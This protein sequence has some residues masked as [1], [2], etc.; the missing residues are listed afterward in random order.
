MMYCERCAHHQHDRRQCTFQTY[1]LLSNINSTMGITRLYSKCK[2]VGIVQFCCVVEHSFAP[3]TVV[4]LWLMMF[5][6][7]VWGYQHVLQLVTCILLRRPRF[8]TK[9]VLMGFLVDRVALV[10]VFLRYFS[11]PCP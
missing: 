7:A 4:V 8:D 9:P 10:Q 6:S 1:G 5:C 3:G 11:F 2:V